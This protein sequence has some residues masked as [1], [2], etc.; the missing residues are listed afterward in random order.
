[1]FSNFF[2]SVFLSNFV[3]TNNVKVGWLKPTPLDYRGQS[4]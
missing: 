3:I 4:T 1:M 2:Y